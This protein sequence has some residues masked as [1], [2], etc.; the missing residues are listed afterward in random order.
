MRFL[1]TADWHCRNKPDG[2]LGIYRQGLRSTTQAALQNGCPYVLF[3]GD[4]I[5]ERHCFII[6]LLLMIYE[7]LAWA[8]SQGVTW[9]LIPGN[10]DIPA[11]H[12]PQNSVLGLLQGVAKVYLTPQVLRG[13]G[14]TIYLSPWRLGE[15]FKKMQ[16]DWI[17]I[18]RAD[19]SPFKLHLA[20]IGLLEGRFSPSNTYRADQPVRLSDMRPEL[21]TMTLCGDYHM[22]Q[23]LHDRLWYVGAPIAHMHGDQQ[24]QGVW[25][26]DTRTRDIRQIPLPGD[27]PQ[28]ISLTPTSELK[29]DLSPRKFYQIH[30]S[31]E[32]QPYYFKTYGKAINVKLQRIPR[33]EERK[34]GR[35][36][37]GVAEGDDEE[38]LQVWLAQRN[39]THPKYL[40]LGLEYL[41]RAK[42]KMFEGQV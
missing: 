17:P 35:R 9:V 14:Y 29:L 22:T 27:W 10:H 20:H 31:P 4:L 39:L 13:D 21:Y 8:K 24:D 18:V 16:T 5:H 12:H 41:R 32:L 2:M 28:F 11:K 38:V 26:V 23:Q 36:L 15:R 33:Q 42:V 6:E 34:G 37:D 1:V 30:C 40:E 19:D 25:L 7:E 3:A